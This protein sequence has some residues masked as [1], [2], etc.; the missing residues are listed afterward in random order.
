M[1]LVDLGE[2]EEV[3]NKDEGEQGEV[4]HEVQKE[5]QQESLQEK[6]QWEYLVP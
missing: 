3:Q 4:Q 2:R 5:P 6:R 1:W